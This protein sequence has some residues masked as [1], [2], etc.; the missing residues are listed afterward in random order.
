MAT[1]STIEKLEKAIAELNRVSPPPATVPGLA[2][3]VPGTGRWV[4]GRA[5]SGLYAVR[6]VFTTQLGG[7]VLARNQ[8]EVTGL[9][10]NLLQ[11]LRFTIDLAQAS[12][13]YWVAL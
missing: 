5:G 11:S 3:I 1:I 13:H 12:R 6:L 9:P 10:E 7:E 4:L 8:S 2:G